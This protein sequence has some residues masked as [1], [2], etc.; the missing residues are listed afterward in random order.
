MSDGFWS[1]KTI[2]ICT[3]NFDLDSLKLLIAKLHTLGVNCS[4]VKRGKGFRI[5]LSSR[6]QNI[7]HVRK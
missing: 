2:F 1:Q 5:R 7:A 3:E 4:H 6:E